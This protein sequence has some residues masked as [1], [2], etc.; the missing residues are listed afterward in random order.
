LTKINILF[1]QGEGLIWPSL[2][3]R[4]SPDRPFVLKRS[5]YFSICGLS[6]SCGFRHVLFQTPSTQKQEDLLEWSGLLWLTQPVEHVF[7]YSNIILILS[8]LETLGISCD[9]LFYGPVL[10][11]ICLVV[12]LTDK[13]WGT[14]VLEM[15]VFYFEM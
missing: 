9:T 2:S 7:S 4:L 11:H 15:N 12:G 13:P 14:V 3:M 5:C 8:K 1:T 6:D 10:E